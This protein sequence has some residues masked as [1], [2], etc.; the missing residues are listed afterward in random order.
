MR[1]R[2]VAATILTFF[3]LSLIIGLVLIFRPGREVP[4]PFKLPAL[5]IGR[6]REAIGL[7]KIYGVIAA[8]GGGGAFAF[9][10]RGA[11]H[12]VNRIRRLADNPRVRAIVIR[13]N[14]PGGTIGASQEIFE[15]IRRAREK[16]IKVVV[17]MSDIAASG[18]YLI[19]SAANYI[20]ANP[21][22]I[23][24]SIGVV[25]GNINFQK[26]MSR[27]GIE[28]NIIKSGRY[29]DTLSSWRQMTEGERELLQELVNRVY[30]QFV[31]AVAHGRGMGIEEVKE[32][33][34]G[35]VFTGEEAL[36]L[37][38]VDR[39]G[40]LQEAIRVAAEKAG[41]KEPVLL[42]EE[43]FPWDRL[44]PFS[45]SGEGE[46]IISGLLGQLRGSPLPVKFIYHP[47]FR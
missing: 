3:T 9:Q 33:A 24:G 1:Q 41:I 32:L 4:P 19:S 14:S 38:L 18:G 29:K 16:G 36:E 26:L 21:G 39:L 5:A 13:V 45:R 37:G 20:L 31:T 43:R 44:F 35:R 8:Q 42:E 7:V 47:P 22:T 15:E 34:D 27:W 10:E 2:L 28:M 17:S 11:T 46:G 25:V 30:L 40:G 23:T 6:G 12:H